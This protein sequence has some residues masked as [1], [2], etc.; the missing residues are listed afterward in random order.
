MSFGTGLILDS[1]HTDRLLQEA[2]GWVAQNL[3]V[4]PTHI[5][6]YMQGQIG[7][8]YKVTTSQ[9]TYMLKTSTN[10]NALQVEAQM[11]HDLSSYGIAVPAVE[12]EGPMSD[13][14]HYALLMHYITPFHYDQATKE[15]MAAQ[16][17]ISLHRI[18]ND[19][20]M[21]GYWY[22]TTIGPFPQKNEQTQ[23]NWGL[24]LGQMRIVPMAQLCYE[25]GLLSTR[26]LQG[27]E[28]IAH[29]LYRYLD[30]GS[31]TPSLIHGDLWE[32]NLCFGNDGAV[33]IDPAL[34]FA[35]REMELAFLKMF[36]TFGKSF[37]HHYC[38]ELP[39]SLE[40]ASVKAPLYEIYP[41]L[42]HAAL[43]GPH[44]LEGLE[45]LVRRFGK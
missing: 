20:R 25:K 1:L 12:G 45:A 10:A 32:G 27:L 42:V 22:D 21:Y 37:W 14:Q 30:L 11:L 13:G 39:L 9:H 28:Y 15:K 16:T 7:T 17:L 18:S 23:Y 29:N 31:I 3:G 44:Y 38:N 41:K 43:Y 34:Y 5:C 4:V 26:M 33:L 40:F 24:F 2:T 35:D 36:N 19:A 6:A 8:I